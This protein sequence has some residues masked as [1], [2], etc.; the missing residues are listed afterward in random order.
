M[1]RDT[2]I[3]KLRVVFDASS[4]TRDGTSL[5]D[6]LLIGPKLQQDLLPTIVRWWQW[7]YVYVA[8]IVKI[9]RQILIDPAMDAAI[10]KEI[11]VEVRQLTVLHLDCV[12]KELPY[13]YS[14][15]TRLVRITIYVCQFLGNLKRQRPSQAAIT[16]I[17]FRIERG[18]VILVPAR[19]TNLFSKVVECVE[20]EKRTASEIQ[21]VKRVEYFYR[22]R[23]ITL[24]W[25]AVV[26]YKLRQILRWQLVQG[27]QEQIWHSWS[28]DY[29]HSLQNRG[30]RHNRMY[31]IIA[32]LL[33]EI[34]CFPFLS[35]SC[36]RSCKS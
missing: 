19:L 11:A 23:F 15:W 35:G 8:D 1:I 32:W 25:Q 21:H 6:H 36:L 12:S 22:T 9:F 10:T 24:P 27:I 5:G 7:R 16:V 18:H 28:K 2:S 30:R 17:S 13:R 31:W 20:G 3:A 34:R 4:K 33:S 29:L 26:R 14:N